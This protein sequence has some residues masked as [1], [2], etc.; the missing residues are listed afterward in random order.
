MIDINPCDFLLRQI[1]LR[2][3]TPSVAKYPLQQAWLPNYLLQNREIP[4]YVVID[5][6]L[7]FVGE[8]DLEKKR[9]QK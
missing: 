8:V 1:V 3:K 9:R 5:H 7:K 4:I 2:F 6:T